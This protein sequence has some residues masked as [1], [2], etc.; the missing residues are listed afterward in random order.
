VSQVPFLY[1]DTA[2]SKP[3]ELPEPMAATHLFDLL[4]TGQL[5]ATP[6]P[7]RSVSIQHGSSNKR[8]KDAVAIWPTTTDKLMWQEGHR[9]RFSLDVDP[10]EEDMLPVQGHPEAATLAQAVSEHQTSKARA[11]ARDVVPEVTDMLQEL[12]YTE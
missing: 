1:I 4:T 3:L 6:R 8:F 11:L 9:M 5:R 10:G 2:R 7:V 12:G